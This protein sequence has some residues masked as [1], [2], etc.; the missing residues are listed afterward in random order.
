MFIQLGRTSVC[1]LGL[2]HLSLLCA[3]SKYGEH[4]Q[5]VCSNIHASIP[6]SRDI[7]YRQERDL[8]LTQSLLQQVFPSRTKQVQYS[9][10][11]CW[12]SVHLRQAACHSMS[13]ETRRM[14]WSRMAL[15]QPMQIEFRPV[16]SAE[17]YKQKPSFIMQ[18]T[19]IA[20][21][22]RTREFNFL[23]S[24]LHHISIKKSYLFNCI[25]K[26]LFL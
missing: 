11:N 12:H 5:T 1:C 23:S 20:C 9:S 15:V 25:Y 17:K 10:K 16:R 19:Y 26:S 24:N 2:E 14:Y 18:L 7:S 3:L 8:Y 22:D 4:P 6:F 21:N 13:G